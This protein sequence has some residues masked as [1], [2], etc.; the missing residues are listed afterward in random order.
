MAPRTAIDQTRQDIRHMFNLWGIHRA[1]YEIIWQ[2][3]VLQSGEKRRLPGVSI[4]YLRDNKWQTVHCFSK[5]HDRAWTLRQV[6]LF[7]DR[8]RIGEKTG[9][10]YEG[11]SFTTA[12]A[13]A[14]GHEQ[15][16]ERE[17]KEDLIEAYDVLGVS[18]DDPIELITDIYKKKSGYYHPDKQN[19]DVEKQTRLNTSYD[20]IMRSRGQK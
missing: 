5:K 6:F 13:R 11:L 7:L 15:S 12:V 3:E 16:Q 20:L 19:G 17:R 8:I 4:T 18:P 9:I 2:E 1:D 10:Q 14:P